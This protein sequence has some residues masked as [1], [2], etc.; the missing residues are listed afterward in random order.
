MYAAAAD[1]VNEKFPNA[2]H[3]ISHLLGMSI[4]LAL[5]AYLR[6][7]SCSLGRLKELGHDLLKLFVAAEEYGFE[8]T[9]SRRYVLAVLNGL[10]KPR[11]FAYP[12][13]AMLSTI[14]PWRLRQMAEELIEICFIKVHGKRKFEKLKKEPGLCIGSE[15]AADLDA[16]A[17][18]QKQLVLGGGK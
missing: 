10:Y 14:V 7:S 12:E 8:R 3:V 16:S 18:A 2:L 1:A 4:E 17:W 9:G 15:Y 13:P 11:A 5:K 6:K